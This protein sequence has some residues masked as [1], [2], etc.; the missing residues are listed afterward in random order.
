[1]PNVL[2]YNPQD[3]VK[4]DV[5]LLIRLFE[6]MREDASNDVEVH[7]VTQRLI[8]LSSFGHTLTMKDYNKIVPTKDKEVERMKQL[9]GAGKY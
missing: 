7:N 4:M 9:S 6:Y 2:Q 5:P 1:M 3:E 8:S